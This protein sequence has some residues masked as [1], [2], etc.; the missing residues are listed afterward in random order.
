MEQ[1]AIYDSKEIKSAFREFAEQVK[2]TNLFQVDAFIK[3]MEPIFRKSGY[4]NQSQITCYLERRQT[5][6]MILHDAPAGDFIINSG[7]IR[8][9]RRI[10]PDAYISLL[11][12][13]HVA[14]LAEFCPYVDEI[15][16]NEGKFVHGNF[17]DMFEDYIEL[18][19]TL[20]KR[21]FDICYSLAYIA[22]SQLLMY[23]S[24]ARIR[25]SLNVYLNETD[26]RSFS[27]VKFFNFKNT[28]KFSTNCVSRPQY[29]CHRADIAF[30]MLENFINAPINNRGLEVW[31]SPLEIAKAQS[32]LENVGHP[33]YALCMGGSHQRKMY[34]PEKYA[35]FIEMVVAEKNNVTFVILGAGR[36]DLKS[37]EIL[38]NVIP[39]IYDKNILDLTDKINYRQS[40]AVL[41]FCDAYIG[42]DT[43]TK[44]LAAAVNCPVL[45]VNCYP[46]DLPVTADDSIS[47]Y[48]PYGVPN[49]IV[50]PMKALLEC[51]IEKPHNSY[52]CRVLNKPHC[53][54][55]I[56]PQI[57]FDGL[58]Y[59]QKRIA[60]KNFKPLYV[61]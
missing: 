55:Q 39:E 7:V 17:N 10:Y 50:R 34:P 22:E 56:N 59:L 20:L 40:A 23:M 30:Y 4:R 2:L 25:I 47:V 33:L 41:K 48:Y 37:A 5:K 18:A 19:S 32:L 53:I 27:S 52:G 12:K 11:V 49:V 3:F 36:N 54:T 61:C 26:E 29:N 9:I 60:G 45:E 35:K 51:S 43:G 28:V 15:I 8:E 58:K 46:S 21:N 1:A 13:S 31:Y 24:G 42:N 6:I 16:L 44:H 14:V 38:K 57:L